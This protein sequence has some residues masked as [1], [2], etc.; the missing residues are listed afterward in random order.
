VGRSDECVSFATLKGLLV[1]RAQVRYFKHND[2]ADCERILREVQAEDRKV[3]A[4]A[5]A[6]LCVF[7]CLW[8]CMYAR[9]CVRVCFYVP[10]SLSLPVG[11]PWAS[12]GGLVLGALTWEG[13]QSNKPVTRRFIVVEGL[14]QNYGNVAPLKELVRPARMALA[15]CV[16]RPPSPVHD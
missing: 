8:A 5:C 6:P 7:V 12:R 13:V 14:Y 1:S 10:L 15:P 2:V 16:R 9:L 11:R 3:C 4:C